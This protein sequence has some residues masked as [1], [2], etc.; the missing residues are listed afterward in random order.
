M[1]DLNPNA[2]MLAMRMDVALASF[3][4]MLMRTIAEEQ[5]L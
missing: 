5:G 3:R 1:L 2:P 4:A